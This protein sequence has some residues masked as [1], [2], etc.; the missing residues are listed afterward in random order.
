LINKVFS[1][2]YAFICSSNKKIF[3]QFS[4][5]NINYHHDSTQIL[6]QQ[7][8]LS[9]NSKVMEII[10]ESSN[11]MEVSIQNHSD[12]LKLGNDHGSD[13]NYP[14][15]VGLRQSNHSYQLAASISDNNH[16]ASS[17]YSHVDLSNDIPNSI[18]NGYDL[19]AG[20]APTGY[21]MSSALS[22][23]SNF[24]DSQGSASNN[25]NNGATYNQSGVFNNSNASM[26]PSS[27]TNPPPPGST[28]HT[29]GGTADS[30]KQIISS[31]DSFSVPQHNGVISHS[32]PSV[33][34]ATTLIPQTVSLSTY[35][36]GSQALPQQAL[37][38]PILSQQ[39][40][41]LVPPDAISISSS[42]QM[43][44]SVSQPWIRQPNGML[45][46]SASAS[47]P[48]QQLPSMQPQMPQSSYVIP[49]SGSHSYMPLPPSQH[50]SSTSFAGAKFSVKAWH[51]PEHN[52]LR[53]NM[54]DNIIALL[55]TRRPNATE[56]WHEK[57]PHMAKRLEDALYHQASTFED[58]SDSESLKDRLKQLAVLMGGNKIPYA[59][60]SHVD[61]QQE[62]NKRMRT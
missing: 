52:P 11:S 31:T 50:T 19:S 39:G 21:S 45:S 2:I 29:S 14:G 43:Q 23:Q 15:E 9:N 34:A 58:Y 51:G 6:E 47:L 49:P 32:I 18:S 56:D 60:T 59:S 48:T 44:V 1:S 38:P 41:M 55:K 54:V 61:I 26:I 13:G 8:N 57:L 24:M 5:N 4:M 36:A 7:V 42:N 40:S 62:A 17:A 12:H 3:H 28:V 30:A 35:M 16:G 46:S 33:T 27:L 53:N 22:N 25:P 37:S 10:P 20:A